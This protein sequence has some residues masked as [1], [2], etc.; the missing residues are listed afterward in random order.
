MVMSKL[1]KAAVATAALGTATAGL[2]A[3]IYEVALNMK[4]NNWI[5]SKVNVVDPAQTA[6][7]CNDYNSSCGSW[8][9][10][11]EHHEEI[12]EDKDG[13][14]LHC[15]VVPADEPSDKW[16]IIVHGYTSGPGGMARYAMEYN[17]RGFNCLL[18]CLR[19]HSADTNRYCSMGWYDKD[20]CVNW[21]NR[22]VLWNPD[23]QIVIHG[24]SMGAATTMLTTGEKLPPNV[25][26]AVS[27]CGYT[28]AA[29]MYKAAISTYHIPAFPIIPAL[30]A[31]SVLRG[32]FSFYKC[33]PIE[34]V[35]RSVTPTLFVHGSADKL[36][37]LH[38]MEEVYNAC[39][40]PKEKFIVEGAAHASSSTHAPE[41]YW[42]HV[43]PFVNKYIK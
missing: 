34:A 8:W 24:E 26:C 1:K 22:I 39:S 9:D 31:Y 36:V 43:E 7:S 10:T 28:S 5:G 19:A 32:N 16:A 42:A 4:V 27:D 15:I 25:K 21:A 20:M 40:A 2:Y 30:S 12:M 14:V 13:N 3:F 38:M 35:A 41:F 33:A 23:A 6:A 18:P 11:H 17:K 29:E 37:P